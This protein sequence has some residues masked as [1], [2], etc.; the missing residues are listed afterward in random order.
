MAGIGGRRGAGEKIPDVIPPAMAKEIMGTR[1]EI[2]A[3]SGGPPGHQG[4]ARTLLRSEHPRQT[5]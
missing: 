5:I 2:I 4:V 1:V 3:I